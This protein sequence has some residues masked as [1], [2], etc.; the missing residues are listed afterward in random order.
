MCCVSFVSISG[1]VFVFRLKRIEKIERPSLSRAGT[2]LRIRIREASSESLSGTCD[3]GGVSNRGNVRRVLHGSQAMVGQLQNLHRWHLM[4]G[5]VRRDGRSEK[6]RYLKIRMT[7]VRRPIF[8]LYIASSI[9]V[10]AQNN[11]TR[12]KVRHGIAHPAALTKTD[13][14]RTV[15]RMIVRSTEAKDDLPETRKHGIPFPHTT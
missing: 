5:P 12:G 11:Y 6:T 7:P 15:P 13:E 1:Y 4:S 2:S 8:K 10:R 14:R 3:I 9:S